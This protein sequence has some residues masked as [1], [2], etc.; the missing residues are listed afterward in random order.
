MVYRFKMITGRKD[1]FYREYELGTDS[2]LYD[3]HRYIQDDLDFDEAQM[4][5]F[6]T[7]DI[8]WNKYKQ[9]ALFDMGDG[10]MDSIVIEDL[11][12]ENIDYL[13]Y[14]FDFFN[15]RSFLIEFIGEAEAEHREHYPRT[16]DGKGNPPDQLVDRPVQEPLPIDD[17]LLK[18]GKKNKQVEEDAEEELYEDSDG[19]NNEDDND[20]IDDND[21]DM[22][23]ETDDV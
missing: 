23:S 22:L 13:V 9:F 12:A 3:F 6:Y 7:S 4:A 8:D 19:D 15:N 20:F 1:G 14:T 16:A 10:A 11:K 21:L 2:T 5:A 18:N 17:L